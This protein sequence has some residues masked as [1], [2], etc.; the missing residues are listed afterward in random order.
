VSSNDRATADASKPPAG[1]LELLRERGITEPWVL[2]AMATVARDRF[3]DPELGQA[4]YDDR[5]LAIGHGQ[6]ISQPFMVAF[7]AQA[8]EIGPE[9]RVLEVGTGSGYG[10]AVLACRA[11]SV[12]TVERLEELAVSA[13]ARLAELSFDNVDVVVGDGTLGWPPL[14]PYDAIVVTAAGPR[15][16]AALTEQLADGGRLIIPVGGRGRQRLVRVVRRGDRLEEVDLG[17]V[18]FVPLIGADGRRR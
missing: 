10:A 3:I 13:R 16:P 6:T 1:F 9:D 17:G 14:A 12:V 8:A 11:Q 18:R 4:A 2:D 5:P 7:M 15:I